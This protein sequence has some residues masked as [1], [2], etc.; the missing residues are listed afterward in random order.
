VFEAN[1]LMGKKCVRSEQMC[2]K[3]MVAYTYLI[4]MFLFVHGLLN[5]VISKNHIEHKNVAT[6]YAVVYVQLTLVS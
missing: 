1:E 6:W 2:L 4:I 3:L 5:E